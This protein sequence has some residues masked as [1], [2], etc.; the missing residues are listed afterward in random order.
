MSPEAT[1][2]QNTR[3]E[4]VER[5]ADTL[6]NY[7]VIPDVGE[8]MSS[9]LL[10]SLNN[11]EYD[12]LDTPIAF[13]E[14]LTADLQAISKDLHVRVR[15]NDESRPVAPPSNEFSPE[16]IAAFTDMSRRANHG[17]Y[18]IE[19]LPG[20]I[21]YMDIRNFW[22]AGWE[23]AGDTA[24]AAMALLYHTDAIIFDLR[25]NGG[26]S[27]TMVAFM[28][29]YLVGSEPVHLNSF[30]DRSDN[31]TRQ[32]WT[33][34]HVPGKRM[35]DKPVYVLTSKRTFSGAEEFSY[36]LKN[37]K[38]A[39]LIGETTGGGAHPGGDVQIHPNYRVFVPTGRPIN[40]ISGTNWEGVGVEPDIAVP[41]EQAL[42]VAHRMALE[43]VLAR[44]G[45]SPTGS[46]R[47]QAEEAKAALAEL[48][49]D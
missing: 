8:K 49:Q 43:E 24:V 37:L 21:G 7:Y 14:R 10:A 22:D 4:V 6:L 44:L 1:I 34:A 9:A 11:G 16:D 12:A 13:C 32:N 19:R 30:Y 18:K 15:Y 31:S 42:T 27:P 26:G 39:T 35:P 36:N 38:R 46:A 47:T 23:G 20:N 17:F 40:A 5:A 28:T 48:Q 45:D 3:R 29:S 41:Q 33:Q 25:K 2:D